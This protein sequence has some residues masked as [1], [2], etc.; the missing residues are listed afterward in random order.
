M[1]ITF[2]LYGRMCISSQEHEECTQIDDVT[3]NYTKL[4]CKVKIGLRWAKRVCVSCT[5]AQEWLISVSNNRSQRFYLE[6]FKTDTQLWIKDLTQVFYLYLHL[7]R[8]CLFY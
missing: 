8:T 5:Y 1:E 2:L 3:C 7:A 4:C 6:G